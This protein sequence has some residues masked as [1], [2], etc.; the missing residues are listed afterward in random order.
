MEYIDALD[1]TKIHLTIQP[2][3]SLPSTATVINTNNSGTTNT[4]ID[5]LVAAMDQQYNDAHD[6]KEETLVKYDS[7]TGKGVP[8]EWIS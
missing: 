3:P 4:D 6:L 5:C 7:T 8:E 1:W 2:N